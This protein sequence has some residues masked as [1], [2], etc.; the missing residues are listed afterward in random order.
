LRVAATRL[1]RIEDNGIFAIYEIIRRQFHPVEIAVAVAAYHIVEFAV[2]GEMIA[3]RC[4]LLHL[5]WMAMFLWTWD[6]YSHQ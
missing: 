5:W 2:R 3:R 4:T 6:T 1:F